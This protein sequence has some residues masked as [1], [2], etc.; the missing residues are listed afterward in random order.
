MTVGELIA[1]LRQLPS[2][3]EIRVNYDS[4]FGES[5]DRLDSIV[6]RKISSLD[7]ELID[8][9]ALGKGYYAGQEIRE[10]WVING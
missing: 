9:A 2:E 10:I 5:A 7:R 3:D 4:D 1:K 8:E 6:R